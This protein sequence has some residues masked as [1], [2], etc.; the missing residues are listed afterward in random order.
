MER[1]GVAA[2]RD[3]RRAAAPALGVDWPVGIPPGE[4]LAGLDARQPRAAAFLDLA[5]ELLRGAGYTPFDGAVPEA[6]GH[7][8][9]GATYAHVT[10]P[11][12]RL[13]DRF[14]T[15]VCLAVGAGREVPGWVREALPLLPDLLA[16]SGRRSRAVQAWR[17]P[18]R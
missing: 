5:A 6:P 4:V 15:E 3:G 13:G 14:T 1:P 12:R 9:V 8:G 18:G 2:D 10:A 16:D 11:I 17:P 7:A